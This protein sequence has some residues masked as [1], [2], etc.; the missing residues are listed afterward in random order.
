MGEYVREMIC[1]YSLSSCLHGKCRAD[2]GMTTN[3][4]DCSESSEANS[5]LAGQGILHRLRNAR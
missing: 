4:M 3:F 5:G 2:F 1:D